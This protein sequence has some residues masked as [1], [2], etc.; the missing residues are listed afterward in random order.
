MLN[1]EIEAAL[2]TLE[3][4]IAESML[5]DVAILCNYLGWKACSLLFR[6]GCTPPTWQCYNQR[7]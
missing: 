4:Q 3:K 5:E 6:Q 2:K 7:F 1:K